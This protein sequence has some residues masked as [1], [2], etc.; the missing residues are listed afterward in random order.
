MQKNKLKGL[1]DTLSLFHDYVRT[2]H[3]GFDL[4]VFC[5]ILNFDMGVQVFRGTFLKLS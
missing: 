4:K 3:F 5:K 2:E 1:G